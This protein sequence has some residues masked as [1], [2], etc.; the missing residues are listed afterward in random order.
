[1]VWVAIAM[2]AAVNAYA[3]QPELDR[4]D[5]SHY[6]RFELRPVKTLTA[7]TP[8][9]YEKFSSLL[10]KNLEEQTLRWAE[11]DRA[12]KDGKRLVFEV[13]LLDDKIN[14]QKH[15]WSRPVRGAS[16]VAAQIEAIDAE[17][18][19][20]IART[21]LKEAAG[22]TTTAAAMGSSRNRMISTLAWRSSNYIMGLVSSR[23]SSSPT[24][25]R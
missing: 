24:G 20:V 11:A 4:P 13:S 8:D 25:T 16:R 2:L 17:S 7:V 15:F 22:A 18:G 10:A 3:E 12:Q 21:T 5:L 9:E 19:A 14:Q 6:S 1:M 23:L